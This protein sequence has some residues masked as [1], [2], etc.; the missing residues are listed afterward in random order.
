MLNQ[1]LIL[2]Y[3]VQIARRSSIFEFPLI[4]LT[5]FAKPY[6]RSPPSCTSLTNWSGVSET[7]RGLAAAFSFSGAAA[8]DFPFLPLPAASAASASACSFFSWRP[9]SGAR[10][11]TFWRPPFWPFR[12]RCWL[13]RHCCCCHRCPCSSFPSCLFCS[14]FISSPSFPFSPFFPSCS[15]FLVRGL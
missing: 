10:I 15:S 7:S 5:S 1:V 2:L 9:P 6:M 3:V 13:L 4:T 8:L 12:L 11:S 14:S